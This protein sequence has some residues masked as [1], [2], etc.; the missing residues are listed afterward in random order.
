MNFK[1][2]KIESRF[3][4]KLVL[5]T[6]I[7][8][9]VGIITAIGLSHIVGEIFDL[10]STN[11]LVGLVLGFVVA[12]SQW[13]VIKKHL[14][15]SSWWVYAASVGVGIPFILEFILS[16]IFGIEDRIIENEILN[17][18][19]VMLL[20]GFITGLLQYQIFKLLTPK[21]KWW[22]VISALAWGLAFPG[23]M[24]AGVINGLITGFAILWILELPLQSDSTGIN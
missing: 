8:W 19:V 22:I 2:T 5:F 12:Y 23:L 9:P 3:L 21:Y 10:Q 17:H 7:A 4:G 18:S 16:I 6:T 14:K 24:L 1:F 13:I 15:I 20:G 11:L